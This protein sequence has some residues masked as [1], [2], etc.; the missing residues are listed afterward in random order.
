VGKAHLLSRFFGED[1]KAWRYGEHFNNP[2][3]NQQRGFLAKTGEH[4]QC[5]SDYGAFD[6]VGNVHEWVS[7]KVDSSLA[8]KLALESGISIRLGLRKGRGV[9]MGGFYSTSNQHGS[10]CNFVTVGHEPAYHDYSTG[11]RC[12]KDA[13]R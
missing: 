5:V 13:A 10:G 1:A 11:F 9:F 6:M 4:A 8:N 3:L 7:D 12:C 2:M